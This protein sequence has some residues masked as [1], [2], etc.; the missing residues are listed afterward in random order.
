MDDGQKRMSGIPR[1]SRLPVSRPT[2][3][4][5]KPTTTTTTIPRPTS[6]RPSRSKDNLAQGTTG[7]VASASKLR[8]SLSQNQLRSK[9]AAADARS[10]R[11]R[12]SPS[13]D[14]LGTSA[15]RSPSNKPKAQ[16]PVA[17]GNSSRV[18]PLQQR[19]PSIGSNTS[20]KDPPREAMQSPDSDDHIFKRRLTL[21]RRPSEVLAMSPFHEA[22]SSTYEPSGESRPP[23]SSTEEN[24]AFDTIKAR[25][26]K[27]RPSLTE[28]TIETLSQV[29]PSPALKKRPSASFFDQGRMSSRASSR[30]GSRPTSSHNSDG[31]TRFPSR[32]ASR[33]GGFLGHEP[34]VP[35]FRASTNTMPPPSTFGLTTRTLAG[36][37]STVRSS[38]SRGQLNRT[39][40]AGPSKQLAPGK[41]SQVDTTIASPAAAKKT[42]GML[43]LKGTAQTISARPLKNRASLTGL[44][45]KPSL[46]ALTK[47]ELEADAGSHTPL[48]SAKSSKSSWDGSV[49]SLDSAATSSTT[50]SAEPGTPTSRKS[51]AALR[52]QIAQ[53]KA[54]KRAAMKK[55]SAVPA[56]SEMESPIVPSDD[57]FDFGVIS[58]D[59]FNQMK[60]QDPKK[61]VLAQRVNAGRTTGRLN[62]AAL[63]LKE[64]PLE[65]MKMYDLES[66]GAQDGSWAE[67]V[68][69]TRF[70]A[71]DNELETLDDF[72]FPD[73]SP[74]SFADDDDNQGSL[75]GGLETLDLHGNMLVGVPLGFRHLAHLTSLNLSSNSLS[76]NS[77][78]TIA[79]MASLRDLKLAKNLF[80]G[81]LNDAFSKLTSLE[82]LDL[83]GNNV[84][85]LPQNVENMTH[86]RILNLNENS[87]ESLPFDSLAK[88]PLTELLVRKNKLS[89]TLI[90]DPIEELP[91]LQTLD[92]SAN[93]LTRLVPLGSAISMPVVHALSLSMNRLQGLPDM[94]SWES[95]LTLTVDENCISSIPN[96]FTSLSKLRHADFSG[97]DIRVVP[98]EISRMDNLSM[99]RLSGNPLRDK[100][101]VTI[102][103]DELKEVLAGRLES[104]VP[105]QNSSR[106]DS[107]SAG[108]GMFA[109]TITET[110]SWP[111]TA[112]RANPDED[113]RSE[114]DDDFATPPT[115]APHSPRARSRTTSSLRSRS[116]TLSNQTWPVKPG[117]LLDRSRTESSSLHPVVCSR[118]VAEHEV[119]QIQLQH[120]LFTCFP[121]S[122]SFFT[123]TLTSLSLAHNQLVGESYITEE[124]DLPVLKEL[125]LTSNHITGLGPLINFLH[126][127]TLEKMDVSL[128]RINGLPSN[129]K[130]A[131]PSLTVLLVANNHLIE[132]EPETISGLKI[133]DASSN[134]ITHL[135]PRIGLLGGKGGLEK[136]DVAGNRFK[137]PRYSVL[138]RG[139][140]ATLRWLRGRVPV[141]EMGTWKRENSEDSAEDFD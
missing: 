111:S 79:Q 100:K 73:T 126:A 125:N 18:A 54:A 102:T 141:A 2:S 43:P 135:N 36:N 52:D 39:S 140:E 4:L 103:T 88:L 12:A 27:P 64:I 67:S 55:A 57:G 14:Q 1:V 118:V 49:P 84:S 65:V 3:S 137:V 59:P 23:S 5:P 133:V 10:P 86:L 11:L 81:P 69:L 108:R 104:P 93:Q 68:D 41:S 109:G 80:F 91:H 47:S 29:P 21:T 136:L 6:L 30:P 8:S 138:E 58:Q 33:D 96:S 32:P 85:A 62:I 112:A 35:N 51:S 114:N 106:Q 42:Y 130:E 101:F 120:N 74:E 116:R 48:S 38:A 139:T 37:Q 90:E 89:G 63:G 121:N 72:M 66:I 132:L 113:S 40:V 110:E 105:Y 77:L 123:S 22:G 76:N 119:K 83:H 46:P 20:P 122:L 7:T 26:A 70:V 53:A 13:R 87:F 82:I 94:T 134:D 97:N 129:L 45:R 19:R 71:A 92:V 31:S 128:N 60:G 17:M 34:M 107:I 78:D 28:R 115:S 127:P 15:V 44:Y 131:F 50:D 16:P 61:K 124:L 99:I 56:T 95:L 117:G 75:F 25:N 9:Y 24:S 98:P